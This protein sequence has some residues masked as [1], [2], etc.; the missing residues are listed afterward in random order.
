MAAVMTRREMGVRDVGC[1]VSVPED[2]KAKLM[3]YL[4][5]IC[6]LISLDDRDEDMKRLTDFE[7]YYVLTEPEVDQLTVVCILIS[8]D[9]L[10]DKCIFHSEDM[11]GDSRNKFF[12]LSSIDQQL[13][14][15]NDILIGGMQTRVKRIMCY[16]MEWLMEYYLIPILVLKRRLELKMALAQEIVAMHEREEADAGCC[17]TIL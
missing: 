8:P 15:S 5:C 6:D 16:K 13:I 4:K 10:A 12:E 2:V 3:F 14:V 1:S 7:R 17:C 11:C 9:L